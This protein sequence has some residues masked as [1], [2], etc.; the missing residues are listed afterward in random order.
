VETG[1]Y[2]Q[3]LLGLAFHPDYANNGYFF[4]YYIALGGD[5]AHI[6]RFTVMAATRIGRS[7]QR[8][9]HYDHSSSPTRTTTAAIS[10]LGPTATSTSP[11]ATAALM[12]DP[13]DRAQDGS[14]LL[15]KT[16]AD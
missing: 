14:S 3:G 8:V 12:G 6:A 16:A 7:R 9:Y 15:G 1:F 4:V 13:D 10:S 2:E 11:W 5:S